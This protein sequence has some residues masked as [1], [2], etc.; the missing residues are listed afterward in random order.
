M[1]ISLFNARSI[2]NKIDRVHAYLMLRC[3]DAFAVTETWLAHDD[4]DFIGPRSAAQKNISS[5]A[6]PARINEGAV[7]KYFTNSHLM[8]SS[9]RA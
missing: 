2:K 7:S 5:S 6:V 8:S 3:P 9:F 1:N 4:D